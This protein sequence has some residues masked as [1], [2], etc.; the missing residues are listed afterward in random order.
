MEHSTDNLVGD[1][2]RGP[3]GDLT[4]NDSG[5]VTSAARRAFELVQ[6]QLQ[7]VEITLRHLPDIQPTAL[8][9]AVEIIVR[10]GGKRIRP[11]IALLIAAMFDQREGRVIDLASAIEML[12]T[13]TLVH[14]DL[15]DGSLM[16]RGASTLNADW[17]PAAT[18]LTGDY[19]FAV[20]A[21]LAARTASVRVMSI[22]SE[23]LGVI[24]AG[25]LRQQF[26]DW[27]RRSTREDY[28]PRIYAKTA[29]MFV[30]AATAT[31]VVSNASEDQITALGEYGRNFG[32]AFQIVDDILDF[33][34]EEANVGKPVGSDLRHG[35]ITLPT[36]C[37][38]E[39]HAD[40]EQLQCALRG[41][42]DQQTYDS[43]IA[44]IRAS[45]SIRGA[46]SEASALTQKAKQ[47]L[48]IFPDSP[49]HAALL[50]LADYTV[51]RDK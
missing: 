27:A 26:T 17:T 42:C 14:D 33:T 9:K 4:A 39:S 30:L 8:R 28:Y 25:E 40:D 6:G 24:V 15:I 16:R 21:G 44:R 13:A 10:S 31:G 32:L 34:G 49:Y 18:V 2:A 19:L 50:D 51:K 1:V 35:L 38:H 12:H 7:Q 5:Y 48:G 20:A 37:Y 3:A 23:T 22:F 11:I 45:D 43:L 29:S 36:I 41:E 47:A 46:L